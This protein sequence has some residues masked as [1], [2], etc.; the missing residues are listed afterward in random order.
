MRFGYLKSIICL[1]LIVAI[2]AIYW[3]LTNHDFVY[4][5]D[6][7]YV[8]EN[9]NVKAGLTR[10]GFIW[11]FTTFHAANWYPL[12]WLS[13]MLDCELFGLNPGMHHLTNLLIHIAN[14][15]LLFLVFRRMTGA[16]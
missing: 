1:V 15:I 2:L 8:T 10:S 6:N 7:E 4:F 16:L 12:T 9:H 5:D 14:S 11:A 13:H 3:Q